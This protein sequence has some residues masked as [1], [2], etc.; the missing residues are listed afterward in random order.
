[1]PG[2]GKLHG[3]LA[4]RHD[5]VLNGVGGGK[6]LYSYGFVFNGFAAEL[7]RGAGAK[8]PADGRRA[9]GQQGRSAR[10][11]HLST[12]AFLGLRD[13]PPASGSAKGEGVVIGI[14][15]SGI[16]PEHPSV[17]DRTGSNGNGNQDGKLAYQQI[18]AARQVHPG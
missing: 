18:P 16:W 15:D 11:R 6:K 4:A 3:V 9:G 12:P 2:R 8:A 14:V 7:T 10:T 17:S 5:A 13:D 1:M